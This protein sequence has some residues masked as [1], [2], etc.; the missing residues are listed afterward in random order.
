M[1]TVQLDT[2]CPYDCLQV[3]ECQVSLGDII[4]YTR[5][6]LPEEPAGLVILAEGEDCQSLRIE[7]EYLL[8]ELNR[9]N[10]ATLFT[11]LLDP[12][13]Q[14]MDIPFDIDIIKQHLVKLTNWAC[15]RPSLRYLPVGYFAAGTVAAAAL[16]ASL[17]NSEI[18]KAVVSLCGRPDLASPSLFRVKTA[19]L[20]LTACEDVY[21][22]ALNRQAFAYLHSCDKQIVTLPGDEGGFEDP[23]KA[24]QIARLSTDWFAH[25]FSVMPAAAWEQEQVLIFR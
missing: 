23:E 9:N 1:E 20:L 8:K 6:Y 14:Q 12:E 7:H 3:E 21:I 22:T 19:T 15:Q 16:E 25:H 4:L 2:L 10:I 11:Y 17:S 18:I 5:L 24:K 13:S